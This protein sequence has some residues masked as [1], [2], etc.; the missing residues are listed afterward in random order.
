[1]VGLVARRRLEGRA[2]GGREGGDVLVAD[3]AARD[4]AMIT[5]LTE[6]GDDEQGRRRRRRH[7]RVSKSSHFTMYTVNLRGSCL[8][9]IFFAA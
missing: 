3:D 1:M 7:Y 4:G 6:L 8:H 2:G 9:F 5:A